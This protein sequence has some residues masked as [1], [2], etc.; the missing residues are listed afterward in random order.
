VVLRSGERAQN[1][2]AL[3]DVRDKS[4]NAMARVAAAK[5]IEQLIETDGPPPG[6]RGQAT[7]GICIVIEAPRAVPQSA[8]AVIDVTPNS[9]DESW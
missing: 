5:T 1:I 8:G 3:V 2:H 6:S 4:G 9:P 7:P